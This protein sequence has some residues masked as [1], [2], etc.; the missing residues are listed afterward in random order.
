MS[1]KLNLTSPKTYSERFFYVIWRLYLAFK[2]TLALDIGEATGW[3]LSKYTNM[4][5]SGV[6][7]FKS[8]RFDHYGLKFTL[9]ERWLE[10]MCYAYGDF[11]LVVFEAVNFHKGVQAAHIYGGFIAILTAWCTKLNIPYYGVPVATIKRSMTGK[12]NASK[13]QMLDKAFALGFTPAD[14]NEAD[15]LALLLY[16]QTQAQLEL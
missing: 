11:D 9:F 16:T 4:I 3:A 14:H 13:Q 2:S 5:S 1:P 10:D 6:Q 12:G 8:K 7:H 15:A